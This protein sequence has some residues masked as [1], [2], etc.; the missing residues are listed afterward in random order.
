M[1]KNVKYF[2]LARVIKAFLQL[3]VLIISIQILSGIIADVFA[4]KSHL[5]FAGWTIGYRTKGNFVDARM[6]FNPSDTLRVYKNGVNNVYIGDEDREILFENDTVNHEIINQFISYDNRDVRISNEISS[7]E[8]VKVRVYSKNK[9][10][11]VFWSIVG[12]VKSLISVLFL[13]VLTKLTNRYMDGDILLPKSFKLFS[14]LGWLLILK[15]VFAYF[16]GIVNMLIMQHPNFHITS[17]PSGLNYD[18]NIS[19]DFTNTGSLSALG[20]GML[21]ILL[22]QVLKQAILIK[23]EQDLTI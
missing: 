6:N 16:I 15:E 21:V 11:N 10:H 14:F 8:N 23:E 5:T 13:I 4:E 3:G 9:I 20:V 2:N 12:Q 18:L 7:S 17:I 1:A 19:L 22:A